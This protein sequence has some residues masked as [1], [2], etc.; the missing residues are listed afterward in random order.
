MAAV[1]FTPAAVRD[2]DGIWAY[3][4]KR[5][6]AGQAANYIHE[7]RTVCERVAGNEL[8]GVDAGDLRPGYRKQIAGR[9]VIYYRTP[10]MGGIDVIR[11]L[12]V[13]MDATTRLQS[14]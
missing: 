5:W 7:I 6:G 3:T 11:I 12:H 2:L 1:R 4:E 14:G 9:H 8:P 13:A 10:P